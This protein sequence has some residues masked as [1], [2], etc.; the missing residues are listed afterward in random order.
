MNGGAG[1][2]KYTLL[3]PGKPTESVLLA[4]MQTLDDKNRMPQIGT[5]AIDDP[6][7]ELVSDWITSI[8]ACP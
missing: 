6:A 1:L 5:Y 8:Q 7:V 4:R 2:S 3:T